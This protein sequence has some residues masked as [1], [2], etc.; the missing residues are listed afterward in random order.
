[1]NAAILA[2]TATPA[3]WIVDLREVDIFSFQMVWTGTL[4]AT[5]KIET[6]NDYF[7]NLAHVGTTPLTTGLQ[8]EADNMRDYTPTAGVTVHWDDATSAFTR[9]GSLPA[10]SAGNCSFLYPRFF[11]YCFAKITVT[12]TSDSGAKNVQTFQSGK[13]VG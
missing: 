4:T 13:A 10:G 5:V 8:S 7:P 11:E 12:P 6:S 3:V 2:N 9:L 1:M